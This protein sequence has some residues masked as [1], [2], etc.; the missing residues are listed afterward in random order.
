MTTKEQREVVLQ[1][2]DP[3]VCSIIEHL[4]AHGW[5]QER[6]LKNVAQKHYSPHDASIWVELESEFQRYWVTARYE[7]MGHNVAATCHAIIDASHSP[8]Q[9]ASALDAFLL[10]VEK[11]IGESFAV[12]F[13]SKSQNF[14]GAAVCA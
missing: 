13:L 6:I 9:V 1:G 14:A 10:T 7:S 12:R 8:A 4:E 11:S 3:M 5:T 2:K